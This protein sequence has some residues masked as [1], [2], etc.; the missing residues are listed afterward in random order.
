MK[1]DDVSVGCR[2]L[3][4]V[5]VRCF[6][7]M[8][9]DEFFSVCERQLVSGPEYSVVVTLAVERGGVRPLSVVPRFRH[10][11]QCLT[12]SKV[13][14]PLAQCGVSVHPDSPVAEAPVP[15]LYSV[16]ED[17]G[18]DGGVPSPV[19]EIADRGALLP[20]LRREQLITTD[21]TSSACCSRAL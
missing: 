17:V 4:D 3:V 15:A 21:E 9:K 8:A 18:A 12:F 19:E 5:D 6:V 1:D 14:E 13:G 2:E 7:G 20:R 16:G 11:T 10:Q